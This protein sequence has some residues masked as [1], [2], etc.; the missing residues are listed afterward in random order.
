MKLAFLLN[1]EVEIIEN[2]G[3]IKEITLDD[4]AEITYT[5]DWKLLTHDFNLNANTFVDK[6]NELIREVNKLKK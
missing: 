2:N 1:V 5:E 3:D 6:I 4:W